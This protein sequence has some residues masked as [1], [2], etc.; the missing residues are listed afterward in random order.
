VRGG[1]RRRSA[2]PAVRR[3][4]DQALAAIGFSR[5]EIVAASPP[6]VAFHF[7][8]VG[9]GYEMHVFVN[10]QY[11]GASCRDFSG[12][13]KVSELKSALIGA[14]ARAVNDWRLKL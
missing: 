2:A 5:D 8:L 4:N 7:G 12:N 13:H 11:L 10:G 6:T 14:V 3:L 9:H 1:R